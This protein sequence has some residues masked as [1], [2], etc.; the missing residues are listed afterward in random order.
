[1]GTGI[2]RQDAADSWR[3][4]PKAMVGAEGC[5]PPLTD[6][7]PLVPFLHRV[8]DQAGTVF[9]RSP[10]RTDS[11]ETM[12]A[13]GMKQGNTGQR[14]KTAAMSRKRE[15]TQ[16]ARRADPRLD[17]AKRTVEFSN[18]LREVSDWTLWWGQLPSK[19]KERPP[20][21]S[22]RKKNKDDD[23]THGPAGTLS[24]NRSGRTALRREQCEQLESNLP[25]NRATGKEGKADHRYHKHSPRKR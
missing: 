2:K 22:P 16:Q 18:G 1:M 6:G 3:N 11:R 10:Y 21:H 12:D 19:R 25:E 14:R 23:G 13:P 9:K 5:W 4:G 17:V 24:G 7:W 20:K 15:G 8:G